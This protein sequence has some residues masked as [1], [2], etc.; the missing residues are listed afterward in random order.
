MSYHSINCSI[1]ITGNQELCFTNSVNFN[2][3]IMCLQ[4]LYFSLHFSLVF[5]LRNTSRRLLLNL[6]LLT[7][8]MQCTAWKIN[9]LFSKDEIFTHWEICIVFLNT[10]FQSTI[11]NQ[12]IILCYRIIEVCEKYE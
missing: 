3:L 10:M 11:M 4:F 9:M 12:Q 6:L 2:H 7:Y 1:V 5:F 8:L